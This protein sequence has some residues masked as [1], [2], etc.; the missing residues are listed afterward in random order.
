MKIHL[1]NGGQAKV[2]DVQNIENLFGNKLPNDFKKFIDEFDGATPEPNVYC[3]NNDEFF[4][5]VNKFIPI[6]KI[7][8]EAEL[9]KIPHCIPFAF[10]EGGNYVLLNLNNGSIVFWDHETEEKITI[11][12]FF[13]DFIESLEPISSRL[14]T[15]DEPTIESAWID[16]EFLRQIQQ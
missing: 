5:G 1:H 4:C 11:A 9:L 12:S 16:P 15:K 13:I 14:N 3:C 2:S 7:C 6:E 10:A 8:E